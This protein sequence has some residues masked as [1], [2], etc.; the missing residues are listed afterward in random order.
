MTVLNCDN[1]NLFLSV[2]ETKIHW[3]TIQILSEYIYKEHH[4]ITKY[5]NTLKT[6][7]F[8]FAQLLNCRTLFISS[9]RS[10]DG[11]WVF[12]LRSVQGADEA[13]SSGISLHSADL[14]VLDARK[15]QVDNI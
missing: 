10:G 13:Y 14:D 2:L 5:Q 4:F 3:I 12:N 6:T 11:G 1:Y 7:I 8:G 15:D 9:G